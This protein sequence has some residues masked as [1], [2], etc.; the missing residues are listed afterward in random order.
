M[1][2]P[3]IRATMTQKRKT[4]VASTS[5]SIPPPSTPDRETQQEPHSPKKSISPSVVPDRLNEP[6]FSAKY[7]GSPN[8]L[9]LVELR[10]SKS[11]DILAVKNSGD[12]EF[13]LRGVFQ[14]A[15]NDFF[16]TP[17]GSFD[18]KNALGTRL[19]G[20]KLNCRLT[21][22][23]CPGFEFAPEDFPKCR[24]MRESADGRD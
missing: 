7:L 3:S 11:S 2:H 19:Q 17:D 22:P 14:I 6:S 4:P 8:I 9:L 23:L 16:F 12:S 21:A 24:A 18:P 10:T 15:R 5:K 20:V 13:I 1:P